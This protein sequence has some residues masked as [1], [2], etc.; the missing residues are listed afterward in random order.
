MYNRDVSVAI[1]VMIRIVW[2]TS[3]VSAEGRGGCRTVFSMVQFY[4]VVDEQMVGADMMLI[5]QWIT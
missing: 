2:N 1:F 4:S 3:Y 5:L